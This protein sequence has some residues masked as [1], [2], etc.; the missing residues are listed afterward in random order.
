M[1]NWDE[2]PKPT[3]ERGE[4]WVREKPIESSRSFLTRLPRTWHYYTAWALMVL[5]VVGFLTGAAI[6]LIHDGRIIIQHY[7]EKIE[8]GIDNDGGK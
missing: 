5:M 6:T 1:K 4:E 8:Y 3:L 2:P 7:V